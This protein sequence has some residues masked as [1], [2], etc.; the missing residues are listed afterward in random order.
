MVQGLLG[1]HLFDFFDLVGD[2]PARLPALHADVR[3]RLQRGVRGGRDDLRQGVAFGAS[4][5]ESQGQDLA[6]TVVYVPC[7][8][9]SARCRGQLT[10]V[11]CSGGQ[12]TIPG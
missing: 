9:G 7:S 8:L 4:G 11:K 12:C 10:S 6:L 2:R 3:G 5:I 1:D